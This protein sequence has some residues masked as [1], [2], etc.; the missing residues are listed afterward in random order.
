VFSHDLKVA[1]GLIRPV[2]P[3]EDGISQL[4]TDW[5]TGVLFYLNRN[6]APLNGHVIYAHSPWSLTSISQRQ[7]WD[8]R[9]PG[10]GA[11]P[12]SSRGNGSVVDILSSI[13][14]AWEE[15]G[16][17]VVSKPAKQ[18]TKNEIFQE[19]WE[20]LKSHLVLAGN[21]KLNDSDVVDR[22]LDPA[23]TFDAVTGVVSG[24]EEPLLINTASSR[25]HR[26]SAATSIPNFFVASDYVATNTDLACMEAA[27]E[28]ARQAVNAIL[29]RTGSTHPPC[30]IQPLKEPAVF[31]F[32]QAIDET[33]YALNPSSEPLLCRYIDEILPATSPGL[34]GS[35]IAML[36]MGITSL[37]ML[38]GIL[39]LLLTS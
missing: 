11:Y 39:Y 25:R 28:A 6:A 17:K 36:L 3:D 30:V 31:E 23:I 38:A 15:P 19:A 32:F 22:F 13:I 2:G 14:S 20:Q 7:F 10:M 9:K 27:N 12:W 29:T 34:S 26:P 33:D 1:A 37:A 5:M 35:T 24:N 18:C 4:E 16:V 8:I 21:G